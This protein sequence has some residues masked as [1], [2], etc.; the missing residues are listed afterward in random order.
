MAADIKFNHEFKAILLNDCVSDY[1]Q[2]YRA[3]LFIA[4]WDSLCRIDFMLKA[5]EKRESAFQPFRASSNQVYDLTE[6]SAEAPADCFLNCFKQRR[7]TANGT[8]T[9]LMAKFFDRWPF[10]RQFLI[11]YDNLYQD[12]SLP[13]KTNILNL[14]F[15]VAI[16]LAKRA[17]DLQAQVQDRLSREILSMLQEGGFHQEVTDQFKMTCIQTYF[18]ALT[19]K[20]NISVC[21]ANPSQNFWRKN[22][23][24]MDYEE[25]TE[26][27]YLKMNFGVLPIMKKLVDAFNSG[28]EH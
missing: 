10:V 14:L 20:D 22:H 25:I 1:K 6:D 17:E 16:F 11:L 23:F 26:E 5:A 28:S 15:Y 4:L 24:Y 18:S 3:S 9:S 7:K 13:T 8:S 27:F 12:M 19:S 2:V 21:F